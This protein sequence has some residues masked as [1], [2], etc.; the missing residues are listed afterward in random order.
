MKPRAL[1]LF[2]KA[3][4]ATKGL[5]RAGFHVT[6]V[7]IEPQP[8]YCGDKF[9]QMD[10]KDIGARHSK[11]NPALFDF[12]WASPPCQRYSV[13]TPIAHKSRHQ[14]LIVWTRVLLNVFKKPYVIENVA[15]AR[16]LL[17]S[18][19]MLCGSM[20]GLKVWRHRYFETS[21]PLFSLLP[22]CDHSFKPVV[23]SGSPRRRRADGTLDRTEPSTQE[24]RDAM[25]IPWMRRT[26][27]DEAIPPAYSEWLGRQFL[28]L[29]Q[30]AAA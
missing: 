11:V 27:L 14:D 21:F 12:I 19:L 24:R 15:G 25:G 4:G 22:P 1:D 10:V 13:C 30:T 6:G 5:Q 17:D 28:N 26:E 20:F 16:H 18:P 8:N 23:V 3:G 9:I 2:C 7:D 29:C